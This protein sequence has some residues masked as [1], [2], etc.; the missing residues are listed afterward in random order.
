[1][2]ISLTTRKYP[3][4]KAAQ[5]AMPLFQSRAKRQKRAEDAA[6]QKEREQRYRS[7]RDEW[8][9][10]AT[11]VR[12][13]ASRRYLR[14]RGLEIGGLHRPLPLHEGATVKYV[15]RLSTE[16]VRQAYPDVADQ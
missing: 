9:R 5:A 1:M 8:K 12:D 11:K 2:T 10:I 4:S 13:F 6:R 14:E 3:R 16:E 15:D 7:Q